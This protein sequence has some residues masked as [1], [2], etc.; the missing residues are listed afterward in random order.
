MADVQRW[1]REH[2]DYFAGTREQLVSAGVAEP[3]WF[4]KRLERLWT[5]D[6]KPYMSN[7]GRT[8]RVRR[9]YRIEGREPRTRLAC[10]DCLDGTRLWT[11]EIAVSE[12]VQRQREAARAAQ[13]AEHVEREQ[14]RNAEQRLSSKTAIPPSEPV[15]HR[16]LLEEAN[17]KPIALRLV[18]VRGLF[19]QAERDLSEKLDAIRGA[20]EY[21]D[22]FSDAE[23]LEGIRE[24]LSECAD[25]AKLGRAIEDLETVR[26][27]IAGIVR[28]LKHLT[29][30]AP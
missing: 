9:T 15:R 22:N 8:Q 3:G 10:R 19:G 27:G 12:K 4:P 24:S 17:L 14:R 30:G 7:T 29:G 11:I 20:H 28:E 1:K 21:G 23:R 16:A 25:S 5:R 13:Y 2:A 26:Q 6:G 18:G